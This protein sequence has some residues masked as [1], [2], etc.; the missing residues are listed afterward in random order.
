MWLGI[1]ANAA[2]V[3]G[4]GYQ[5]AEQGRERANQA[6]KEL[7]SSDAADRN[8]AKAALQSLGPDAVQPLLVFLEDLATNDRLRYETGMEVAASKILEVMEAAHSSGDGK[9]WRRAAQLLGELE[10]SSRLEG[11]VC[12]ILG[13]LC[14][15]WRRCWKSLTRGRSSSTAGRPFP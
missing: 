15:C 8:S 2:V 14:Q 12:E 1:I 6:I 11:D 4:S 9:E 7:W 13:E 10:I 3:T 5:E